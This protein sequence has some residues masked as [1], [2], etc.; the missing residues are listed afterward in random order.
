MVQ[1]DTINGLRHEA[2]NHSVPQLG[3]LDSFED[4]IFDS[5]GSF[6]TDRLE[7]LRS[8]IHAHL[9]ACE[10]RAREAEAA[11]ENMQ[12]QLTTLQDTLLSLNN[13]TSAKEK[14]QELMN[15]LQAKEMEVYKLETTLDKNREIERI[16]RNKRPWASTSN[17]HYE[18]SDLCGLADNLREKTRTLFCECEIIPQCQTADWQHDK[19][20]LTLLSQT[21]G[22]HCHSELQV[23]LHAL[24]NL[25]ASARLLLRSLLSSAICFWVLKTEITELAA[26]ET[27]LVGRYRQLLKQLS[28]YMGMH[29]SETC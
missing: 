20:L 2:R 4:I 6:L 18:L 23:Q 22:T 10:E 8:M 28:K 24:L 1:E 19:Y 29:E 7:M 11:R 26:E 25:E 13:T 16:L 17:G 14:L 21:F 27:Q 5:A 15:R 3:L 12:E 9:N